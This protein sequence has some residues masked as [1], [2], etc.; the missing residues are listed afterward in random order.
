MYNKATKEEVVMTDIFRCKPP[1]LLCC[2]SD[3]RIGKEAEQKN[4]RS[5]LQMKIEGTLCYGSV[6]E[7]FISLQQFR[8]K[9]IDVQAVEEKWKKLEEVTGLQ[10]R[11]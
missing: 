5:C 8:D 9:G 10:V 6:G 4:E 2:G 3:V 1:C 7:R 11:T